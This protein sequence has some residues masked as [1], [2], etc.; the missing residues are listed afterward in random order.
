MTMSMRFD[1]KFF[2]YSQNI[3]TPESFIALLIHQK[4]AL[5]S[6]LKELKPSPC[7]KIIKPLTLC[8]LFPL[9]QHSC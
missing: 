8:N 3:D 7:R 9:P 1:L 6:L 2:A 4:L 5:L